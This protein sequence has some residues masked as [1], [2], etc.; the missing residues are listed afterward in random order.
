MKRLKR[1]AQSHHLAKMSAAATAVT[2]ARIPML[3]SIAC[4]P[5]PYSAH[6]GHIPYDTSNNPGIRHAP[7][8]TYRKDKSH[9]TPLDPIL[10][11][12]TFP[13]YREGADAEQGGLGKKISLRAFLRRVRQGSQPLGCKAIEL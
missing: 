4:H 6:F 9:R 11:K 12:K 10:K 5:P 2:S 13:H 1:Q 8:T 3:L 7:Q